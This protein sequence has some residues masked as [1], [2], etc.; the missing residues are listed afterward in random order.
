MQHDWAD[1]HKH[2]EKTP[3]IQ[4]LSGSFLCQE[5]EAERWK[6]VRPD[7]HVH[8]EADVHCLFQVMYYYTELVIQQHYLSFS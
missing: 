6:M 7:S 1:V 8:I 3:D 2:F 5:R 4:W